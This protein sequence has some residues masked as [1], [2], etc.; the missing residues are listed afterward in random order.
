MKLIIDIG[1]T[2]VKLALFKEDKLFA[3][4]NISSLSVDMVQKFHQEELIFKSIISSVKDM[5]D[6]INQI[7][8]KYNSL[9]L[10]SS[11]S[12]P[13]DIEYLTPDTL[14]NDRIAAVVAA[15]KLYPGK[16]LAVIDCGTCLTMDIIHAN[17]KYIGG[18][19]SPGLFMRY[20]SLCNFTDKLP[21]LSPSA[22][23]CNIGND[24]SLSI[25]TG[26][27]RGIISE[28]DS[29]IDDFRKEKPNSCVILT[30]GDVNF[31]EKELKNTIFVDP[32]LV[33][34]G[35]NEILDYNE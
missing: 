2:L 23:N 29:F 7:I 9:V 12:L 13:I 14:G 17:K 35:L 20:Q 21:N 28:I 6:N 30:G 4:T 25:H 1:N 24:T 16:D 11:L 34:K 15:S 27:Q 32:Y 5:D 18:R 19:I 22:T 26:I 31:F 3:T 8:K 33:V 10:T